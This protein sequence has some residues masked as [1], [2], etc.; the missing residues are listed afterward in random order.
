MNYV[1]KYE[2]KEVEIIKYLSKNSNTWITSKEISEEVKL[3]K[4]T[5]NKLIKSLKS[6]IEKDYSMSIE[7]SQNKGIFFKCIDTIQ[8]VDLI[9][10]VYTESIT[11]KL[12]TN[13]LNET[14]TSL[15]K[16]AYENYVSLASVR[17]SISYLNTILKDAEITIKNNRFSGNE[18]NI[19]SFLFK[20]YW[21][22]Y[23]GKSWPF[24]NIDKNKLLESCEQ[25]SKKT[26]LWL[27]DISCEQV[28]YIL[29]ISKI[30]F[31]KNHEIKVNDEFKKLAD[32][33]TMF[34]VAGEVWREIFPIN[35]YSHEEMQYYFWVINS[36][37]IDFKKTP[38]MQ[39]YQT[40][41]F[42][43]ENDLL[44]Y[45][46]TKKLFCK[47]SKYYGMK[48]LEEKYPYIFLEML[49][50]H[51]KALIVQSDILITTFDNRS[52]TTMM[53]DNYSDVYKV[54]GDTLNE[55]INKFPQ[56][57][58]SKDYLLEIYCIFYFNIL[59]HCF[60]KKINVVI[61]I[62]TGRIIERNILEQLKNHFE[63]KFMIEEVNDMRDVDVVITDSYFNGCEKNNLLYIFDYSLTSSDY[64]AIEKMVC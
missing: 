23:K 5:V 25:I 22:I 51:N 12:I 59:K 6:K 42:F 29:A 47:V 54:V 64:L 41:S 21:E 61:S 36:F 1:H 19:R 49:F 7:V 16:F 18:L 28:N 53:A 52:Y 33:N 24:Q 37:S 9:R 26:N 27:S 20:Y 56:L 13:L 17:R 4:A 57:R 40:K 15:E 30:R 14:I 60:L 35:S 45:V 55:F 39:L 43:S 34:E 2:N 11:Y 38:L 58:S 44:S 32:N 31:K 46:I 48:N 62:S 3:S 63:G 8:I 10:V 50:H